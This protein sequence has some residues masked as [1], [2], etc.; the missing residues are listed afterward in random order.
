MAWV[1]TFTSE[2]YSPMLVAGTIRVD[3]IRQGVHYTTTRKVHYTGL[4]RWG[5]TLSVNVHLSYQESW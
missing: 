2:V 4:Y 1:G 5:K 3:D